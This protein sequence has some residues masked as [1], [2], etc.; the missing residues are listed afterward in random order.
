MFDLSV[1][2]VKLPKRLLEMQLVWCV[3]AL[4]ATTSAAAFGRGMQPAAAGLHKV[5]L[6][7]LQAGLNSLGQMD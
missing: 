5:W 4:A 2:Q 7:G 1:A 6:F 3:S